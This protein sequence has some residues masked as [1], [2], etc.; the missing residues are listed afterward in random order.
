M[1]NE[2]GKNEK[3]AEFVAEA[4]VMGIAVLPPDI[5][6]SFG[7]F[8][9]EI[10]EGQKKKAIRYGMAGVKNVGSG[11]IDQ[12]VAAREKGG[13]FAD[14]NDLCLRVDPHL[15]NKRLMESLIRVGALDAFGKNR[16]TIEAGLDGALGAASSTAKEKASGQISLLDMLDEAPALDA[17]SA[18]RGVAEQPDWDSDTLLG[19]ENELLGFY[20]SGHPLD[21]HLSRL[22][23]FQTTTVS[24]LAELPEG[25]PVRLA[26]MIKKFEVKLSKK[27]GNNLPLVTFEDQTGTVEFML[28]GGMYEKM[29]KPPAAKDL[30]VLTANVTFRGENASLR[31]QDYYLLDEAE[32]KLLRGLTLDIDLDAWDLVKWDA[33]HQLILDHPGPARLYFRCTRG[34]NGSR[35]TT[36]LEPSDLFTVAPRAAFMDGLR[37]LLGG[38]RYEIVASRE[39]PRHRKPFVRRNEGG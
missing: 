12:I 32:S 8:T 23:P 20:F 37:A 30:V 2:I 38:P 39:L 18:G 28:F 36:V 17:A 1:S 33:L 15:L 5:N 4:K 10:P 24:K 7:P 11:A 21:R 9:V 34:E 26:G 3:I 25:T 14:L 29:E 16:P 22:R 6:K 31:A 13:P 27:T 19:Y 35:R